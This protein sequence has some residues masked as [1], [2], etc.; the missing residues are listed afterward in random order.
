METHRNKADT[1]SGDSE[2]RHFMLNDAAGLGF[3]PR[4]MEPESIVRPLDD[5][6][7][8]YFQMLIQCQKS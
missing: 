1:C 3:E 5:P 7:I 8:L 2:P 6:A 4:L